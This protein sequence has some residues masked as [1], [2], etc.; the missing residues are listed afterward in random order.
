[1]NRFN[2][3]VYA[4][5]IS[6]QAISTCTQRQYPKFVPSTPYLTQVS[7]APNPL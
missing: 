4:Q 5:K 1:M 2:F 6:Y 3:T 7:S